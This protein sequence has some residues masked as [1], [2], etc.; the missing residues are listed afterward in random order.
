MK[1]YCPGCLST[2]CLHFVNVS[3]SKSE[4]LSNRFL[5]F[6]ISLY[7]GEFSGIS[8]LKAIMKAIKSTS[9][10]RTLSFPNPHPFYPDCGPSG[11]LKIF[12]LDLADVFL[13]AVFSKRPHGTKLSLLPCDNPSALWI[14]LP[15]PLPHWNPKTFP[16]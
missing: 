11:Y 10:V 12:S 3:F 6:F 13:D 7:N 4:K 2:Q 8:K 16:D 5:W 9:F 1:F 14:K 15:Y